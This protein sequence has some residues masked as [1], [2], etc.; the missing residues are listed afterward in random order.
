M[1]AGW[2]KKPCEGCGEGPHPKDQ[3]CHDCKKLIEDGKAA[4]EAR[5][6]A[7]EAGDKM[8]VEVP[9][10]LLGPYYGRRSS[11]REDPKERIQKQLLALIESIGEKPSDVWRGDETKRVENLFDRKYVSER[12]CMT[13]LC[14]RKDQVEHIRLLLTAIHEITA[15]A[16]QVGK[17]EGTNLLTGLAAGEV[18]ID[19]FNDASVKCGLTEMPR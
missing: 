15:H 3:L 2:T 19:Q 18:S 17:Q 13:V 9:N 7:T 12:P 10:Y 11:T 5:R 8:Y 14:I 4:R 1:R 16:F 6:L